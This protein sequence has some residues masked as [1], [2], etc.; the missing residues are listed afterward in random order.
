MSALESTHEIVIR[1]NQSW[2]HIDWRGILQYK[3]LIALMVRRDF[4]A[5]YKQTIL[6]PAWAVLNPVITSLTFTLV[7]SRVL[8]VATGG[9][10]PILFYLSGMLGWTYFSNLLKTAS[11][12]LL[13]NASL[14]GKVYFPRLIVPL[15]MAIS[16]LIAFVIQLVTFLVI[17]GFNVYSGRATIDAAHLLTALALLPLVVLHAA[18]L[19]LGVGLALASITAKYRDFQHLTGFIVQLWMY[20]SPVIFPFSHIAH[21]FPGYSWIAAINPMSAVIENI[22]ALFFGSPPLPLPYVV[23]SAGVAVAVFVFGVLNYQR[24]SRTF[25]DIA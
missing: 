16:S 17:L 12:A 22:R 15:S 18:L 13:H 19:A 24:T 2:L 4:L 7:F 11:S 21:K 9:V 10:P 6:G 3:D 20:V 25:I 8:G 23:L 1:P 5:R 14:F